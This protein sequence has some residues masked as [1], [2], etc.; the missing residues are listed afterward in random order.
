[1]KYCCGL[2]LFYPL[3]EDI[4]NI[5]HYASFFEKTYII[6]NTDDVIYRQKY[7]NYIDSFIKL[8]YIT[9]GK[10]IGLSKAY[11]IMCSKAISEK[12]DFICLFDQDSRIDKNNLLEIINSINDYP[13]NDVAIF[14]PNVLYKHKIKKNKKYY[15]KYEKVKWVI[16]SGSFINLNIYN[17]I[18]KFDENLFIDRIDYDYCENARRNNYK[19]IKINTAFIS[20]NLGEIKNG[21]FKNKSNHSVV[22][23]YYIFRNRFYYY[24]YK[25]KGFLS[26]IYC[27]I[28]TAKH[29]CVILF[30]ENNKI[31]K[32]SLVHKAYKDYSFNKLGKLEDDIK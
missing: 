6:D 32:L 5:I 25:K 22:R 9:Y 12:F 3:N 13:K 1:M 31:K 2:V 17:N 27:I 28:L 29:L 14:A 16:S 23:H 30:Y 20:Q 21:F 10:N 15:F 11:N 26:Y 19:I 18:G 24:L 4:E 8:E 7:K